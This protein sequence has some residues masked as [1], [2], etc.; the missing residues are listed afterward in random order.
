MWFTT[1]ENSF[2]M[3]S[4]KTKMRRRKYALTRGN[5]TAGSEKKKNKDE[6]SAKGVLADWE[7]VNFN[8]VIFGRRSTGT[9]DTP[10]SVPDEETDGV[11]KRRHSMSPTTSP[12]GSRPSSR[13]P[14]WLAAL[15][16]HFVMEES[17]EGNE[18]TISCLNLDGIAV[19]SGSFSIIS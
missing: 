16:Y 10:H 17:D 12:P 1:P 9:M 13:P 8:P 15:P 4:F 18:Y 7:F 11:V 6:C 19:N 14:S 2:R 5:S 3:S